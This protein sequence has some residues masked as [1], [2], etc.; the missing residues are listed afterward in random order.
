MPGPYRRGEL[1]FQ[2]A[3]IAGAF[4]SNAAFNCCTPRVIVTAR[5]WSDR[6]PFLD[7]LMAALRN[8]A[9]R[10]AYYPGAGDRWNALARG[11]TRLQPP[12]ELRGDESPWTLLPALDATDPEEPAFRREAFCAILSETEV[13]SDDPVEFLERSVEFVNNRL[14]GTLSAD[15]VVHPRLFKDPR[16]AEAVNRAL[17]RLRYGVVTVNSWTGQAFVQGSPPWGAY[18]GSVPQDIQSGTG[19]VHNTSMLEGIE[20]VVLRHPLTLNPKPAT[21]PGHRTADRLM[22]RMTGLEAQP[23]WRHVPGVIAAAVRG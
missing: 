22:R 9:P 1:A 14:W 7:S 19:W 13:A 15:L 5:G 12:G 17:D 23:R 20:K 8:A 11:R 10:R 16:T 2:A 18:P 4:T 6:G 21:F 3:S